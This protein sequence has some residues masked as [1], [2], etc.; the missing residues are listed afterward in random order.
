MA[1]CEQCKA[2]FYVNIDGS[3]SVSSGE[4]EPEPELAPVNFAAAA[5]DIESIEELQQVIESSGLYPYPATAA[6]SG[7]DGQVGSQ[8]SGVQAD[9]GN[10]QES[11]DSPESFEE[12]LWQA[13][14]AIDAESPKAVPAPEVPLADSV[15]DEAMEASQDPPIAMK[16]DLNPSSPQA[17][18]N[19][20]KP[21][22]PM[23]A[24]DKP[25]TGAKDLLADIQTFGNSDRSQAREG[26]FTYD[27]WVEGIDTAEERRS[28]RD[29]LADEKLMLSVEEILRG[30]EEGKLLLRN[31]NPVKASILVIEIEKSGMSVQWRQSALNE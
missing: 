6:E 24:A 2:V 5:G 12:D 29:I 30:I 18:A 17:S 31:L 13:S 8:D 19:F 1:Q 14:E 27:L 4:P 26:L 23:P 20:D 9:W 22:S 7:F 3:V 16:P 25:I 11:Q 21:R 10:W 28:L 15:L